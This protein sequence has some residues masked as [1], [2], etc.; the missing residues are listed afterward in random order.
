MFPLV[1]FLLLIFAASGV[2][3]VTSATNPQNGACGGGLCFASLL[4]A[5][6]SF[7]IHAPG[8]GITS[9]D[10][11]SVP[12]GLIHT[13]DANLALVEPAG[14]SNQ[15]ASSACTT[16]ATDFNPSVEYPGGIEVT[17]AI[18]TAGVYGEFA[19]FQF[20]DNT[21][22]TLNAAGDPNA[23]F[24]F[25]VSGGSLISNKNVEVVLI[26]GA[27]AS[28]VYW[29]STGGIY[30][31]QGNNMKGTFINKAASV[32]MDSDVRIHGRVLI[33]SSGSIDA[34]TG[35]TGG[36]MIHTDPI[37]DFFRVTQDCGQYS[38]YSSSWE[39]RG[40]PA[41]LSGRGQ[42]G[43]YSSSSLTGATEFDWESLNNGDTPNAAEAVIA[44]YGHIPTVGFMKCAINRMKIEAS[45]ENTVC[46][47]TALG[48]TWLADGNV[49]VACDAEGDGVVSGPLQLQVGSF[50][51]AVFIF[52][53]Y[54]TLGGTITIDSGNVGQVFYSNYLMNIDVNADIS[55]TT[56]GGH[57]FFASN[58]K[59]RGRALAGRRVLDFGVQQGEV[60][61]TCQYSPW[62]TPTCSVACGGGLMTSTRTVVY[63]REV[64]DCTDPLTTTTTAC[65]TGACGLWETGSF[66]VCSAQCGAGTQTRTVLCK[67]EGSTVDD[68][69]CAGDGA[70]PSTT[71]ACTATCATIGSCSQYA[72]YSHTGMTVDQY[73]GVYP[74]EREYPNG[75]IGVKG[76]E[77]TSI[78]VYNP[79]G[80]TAVQDT[81]CHTDHQAFRADVLSRA[82]TVPDINTIGVNNVYTLYDGVYCSGDGPIDFLEASAIQ[83][84]L[85]F[86]AQNNA[87]AQFFI[88]GYNSIGSA[89]T[90][91]TTYQGTSAANGV[92]IQF[93][94]GATM[95][96]IFFVGD[97]LGIYGSFA[98]TLS[99]AG[100]SSF[101]TAAMLYGRSLN[102]AHS[103][104]YPKQTTTILPL[105]PVNCV[106]NA[107]VDFST[108]ST[109]CGGGTKLQ[110]RTAGDPE[111]YGGDPCAG[112]VAQEVACNTEACPVWYQGGFGT[113]SKNCGSGTQTQTVECRTSGGDPQADSV[114]EA[115]SADIGAKP[116]SSQ[117]C[118]IQACGIWTE[119]S[120][121]SCSITCGGGTQ[122]R[123]SQCT[124]DATPVV[125]SS[126]DADTQ[127]VESQACNTDTCVYSWETP[128][129]GTCSATCDG[130]TQTRTV[131]CKDQNGGTAGS[132]ASCVE[133]KPAESQ[134]CNTIGCAHWNID[135]TACT[136]AC[137]VEEQTGVLTCQNTDNQTIVSSNCAEAEPSNTRNCTLPACTW[138]M[139]D[140]SACNVTCGT[141]GQTREVECWDPSNAILADAE[142]VAT[143]PKPAVVQVCTLAACSVPVWKNTSDFGNCSVGCGEG[144]RSRHV[145]CTDQYDAVLSAS[146]CFNL[147]KPAVTTACTA[148]EACSECIV[149][150]R[151][152]HGILS[153]SII[154]PDEDAQFAACEHNETSPDVELTEIRAGTGRIDIEALTPF[155]TALIWNQSAS[156]DRTLLSSVYRFTYIPAVAGTTLQKATMSFIV[157]PHTGR[158][159]WYRFNETTLAWDHK[160]GVMQQGIL[161]FTTQSFSQYAVLSDPNDSTNCVPGWY[162][163]TCESACN[164]GNDAHIFCRDGINGTGECYCAERMLRSGSSPA[165]W[166]C[167][168]YPDTNAFANHCGHVCEPP[169]GDDIYTCSLGVNGTGIT[170]ASELHYYDAVFTND[171]QC[172]QS[173]RFGVNCAACSCGTDA[174]AKCSNGTHGDG[175]CSCVDPYLTY[176]V[177]TNATSSSSS[178]STGLTVLPLPQSSK[179]WILTDQGI[180]FMAAGG[181]ALL[182]VGAAAYSCRTS[183]PKRS[184]K[185]SV[186]ERT[187]LRSGKTSAPSK[188]KFVG[189]PR[190]RGFNPRPVRGSQWMRVADQ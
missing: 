6:N 93:L 4:S 190:P 65:N 24:V 23:E 154:D 165:N 82:C 184:T 153:V 115:S 111:R 152:G 12:S 51:D 103:V 8:G 30:L 74:D 38:L 150:N 50:P 104:S 69:L 144:V 55:G 119:P 83:P 81:A 75:K 70:K 173:N 181:G 120:F 180:I 72:L 159:A 86:D 88:R 26:N 76:A 46:N 67:S 163:S 79:D 161:R 16:A 73:A 116:A 118:N 185:Q 179:N 32:Q 64:T 162:G 57:T 66:G 168:C 21:K 183:R 7:A 34:G 95:S 121:G 117:V 59:L 1:A 151:L 145:V 125:D 164:C 91:I 140:F 182:L 54:L 90:D 13:A 129:F 149:G 43:L 17:D 41:V 136:K 58:A 132:E 31:Y 87:N 14:Q 28:N 27:L 171:C 35:M 143:D 155:D 123:D 137:G 174:N 89:W 105:V 84:V 98:G 68:S 5:C 176:P 138:Q 158:V 80:F 29:I 169:T 166:T 10:W 39:T 15:A 99:A 186:S 109:T 37:V 175:S 9:T 94:N 106:W 135:W 142:C 112:S 131:T 110:T 97:N 147:T 63:T 189:K 128:V 22:I 71:Q 3:A 36:W 44:P 19:T 177:C 107:W 100:T 78:T 160:G 170:C 33:T 134:A 187:G 96:M 53:G 52:R 61:T 60:Y 114:C 124:I 40:R 92:S 126:C 25:I 113:C 77:F 141:G 167:D 127:P 156:G 172:K 45:I 20:A 85:Q 108:C 101:D 122:T 130:G 56:L 42:L 139:T 62:S 157:G 133:I 148:P 102:I 49:N 48:S 146:A 188:G 178:S 18:Y 11:V 47:P 2:D